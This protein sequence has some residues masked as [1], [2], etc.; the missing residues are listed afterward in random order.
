MQIVIDVPNPPSEQRVINVPIHFCSG[1]VVD[2]GGY[3]FEVLPKGHGR[4]I[5]ADALEQR[6]EYDMRDAD[7]R[8]DFYRTDRIN[9]AANYVAD[10]ESV[11]EADK[12]GAEE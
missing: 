5:D 2:A 4:L 8:C 12:E 9:T 11:V 3:G 6:L 10:T 7:K 1:Q